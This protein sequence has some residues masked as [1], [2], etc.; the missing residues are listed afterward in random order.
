MFTITLVTT[1]LYLA[2]NEQIRR[3]DVAIRLNLHQLVGKDNSHDRL[4]AAGYAVAVR[5]W[6]KL[7]PMLS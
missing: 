4:I 3:A 6:P 1:L 7:A 2:I 5:A